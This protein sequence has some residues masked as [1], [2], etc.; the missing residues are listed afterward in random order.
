[1]K[2]KLKNYKYG[3]IILLTVVILSIPMF[4]KNLNVYSDDG[5]QHIVRAYLTAKQIKA[6][7]NTTVLSALS[8]G[9][10]YSWNL[11]YGPLSSFL[12]AI[13]YIISNN[14][15]VAYKFVLILGL[16]LSRSYN[17]FFC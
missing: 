17:V 12:V 6:G 14:I 3:L 2:N 16:L 4:W 5:V 11:F 8:N 1:M 10:G 7:Q 9:F 13:F 15:I